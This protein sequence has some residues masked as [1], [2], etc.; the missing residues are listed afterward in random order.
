[1]RHPRA[2]ASVPVP[3]ARS[4]RFRARDGH[5]CPLCCSLLVLL[6]VV[7]C[8]RTSQKPDPD[9]PPTHQPPF[10]LVS[11]ISCGVPGWPVWACPYRAGLS[12]PAAHTTARLRSNP[13]R[14]DRPAAGNLVLWFSVC[15]LFC[16]RKSAAKKTKRPDR[17]SFP[18]P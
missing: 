1:M 8:W 16:G 11:H 5:L 17:P 4:L 12:T 13:S 6:K 2:F 9:T 3:H 15:G 14:K 7:P 10:S 18:S